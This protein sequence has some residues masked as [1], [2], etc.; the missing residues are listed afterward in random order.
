MGKGPD[1][2]VRVGAL[3]GARSMRF[4]VVDTGPGLP[5]GSEDRVFEPYC[6]LTEGDEQG[7]GLGLATVKRLVEGHGGHV[8][9]KSTSGGCTFWF[10]LPLAT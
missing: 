2:R 6:R 4:E 9:V 7:L 8:G 10:D 1:L 3:A 5:P